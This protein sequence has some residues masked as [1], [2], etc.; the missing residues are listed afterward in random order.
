MFYFILLFTAN[1][2]K[3]EYEFR[4]SGY[5]CFHE[6]LGIHLVTS[7]TVTQQYLVI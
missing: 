6:L 4:E 3:F 7:K 2:M 1:A 5:F